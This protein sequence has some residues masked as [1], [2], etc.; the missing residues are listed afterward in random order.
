MKRFALATVI[1]GSALLGER[2]WPARAMD[3][4][5]QWDNVT[6]EVRKWFQ[7]LIAPDTGISCCGSADGY[8][9]KS[10]VT[11]GPEYFDV[12]LEDGREF[13]RV[14]AAKR[15]YRFGNPTGKDILFVGQN[16]TIYCFVIGGGV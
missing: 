6:P 16:D 2:L 13:K 12:I 9:V 1:L 14:P 10:W 11:N 3:A 5:G 15:T 4:A 8:P 7:S